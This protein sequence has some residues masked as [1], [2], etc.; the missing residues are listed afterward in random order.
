MF[1]AEEARLQSVFGPRAVQINHVGST[2]VPGL[3]AKPEIDVLVV[4]LDHK[5]DALVDRGM[6]SLGYVRG[7]NLS[8]G[9]HFYRRDID[10]VRTHKVHVCL[11]GHA[12]I[13]RMLHFRDMLR[14]DPDLRQRYEDLKVGLEASNTQG[15]HEYLTQK[16]PFIEAVM[17]AQPKR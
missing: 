1:V 6:A 16:A 4:V 2:A 3:A 15:I 13:S 5:D 10:G 14:N 17:T 11:V 8:E 12:Q 9:H 7:K